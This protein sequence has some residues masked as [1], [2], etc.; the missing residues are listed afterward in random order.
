MKSV[1]LQILTIISLAVAE[2]IYET[3]TETVY[4]IKEQTTTTTATT[5]FNHTVYLNYTN[6]STTLTNSSISLTDLSQTSSAKVEPKVIV[7]PIVTEIVVPVEDVVEPTPEPIAVPEQVEVVAP[8]QAEV[9]VPE[10]AEAVIPQPKTTPKQQPTT[11]VTSEKPKATQ[12]S[13][14]ELTSFQ[15][16][17]LNAHNLKRAAHGVSPLKWSSQLESYAQNYANAYDCSGNLK[18]TGGPYGENLAAGFK[19]GSD[20]TSASEGLNYDYSTATRFDHFTQVIWKSTT[21]LG[22]AYKDCSSNN[23]GMYIICSYN[24]PG[25]FVGQGKENLMPPV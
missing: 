18:H 21:E 9:V 4:V 6:S 19:S 5:Y 2:T 23:W 17:I 13:N 16:D 11:L 7:Q 12:Q 3:E 20:C 14:S 10:Q 8:E 22:C 25:N 1:I 24:P 15:S